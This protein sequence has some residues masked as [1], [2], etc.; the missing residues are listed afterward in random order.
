M[1]TTALP[2]ASVYDISRTSWG[3]SFFVEG[4]GVFG[5]F[6]Q[7]LCRGSIYEQPDPD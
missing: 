6:L 4:Y 1:Q 3:V 5:W 2:A 7:R